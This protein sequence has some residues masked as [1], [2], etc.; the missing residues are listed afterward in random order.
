MIRADAIRVVKEQQKDLKHAIFDDLH[1]YQDFLKDISFE[2]DEVIIEEKINNAQMYI[3][4]A[5]ERIS[6]LKFI[7]IELSE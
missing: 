3:D 1:V 6:V 7:N 2:D 4:R 5:R